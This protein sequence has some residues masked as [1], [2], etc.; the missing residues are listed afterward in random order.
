MYK[1]RPVLLTDL[2]EAV[3]C[4]LQSAAKRKR[5]WWCDTIDK[6]GNTRLNSC[7]LN[8]LKRGARVQGQSL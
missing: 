7:G 3:D 2:M 8:Y 6:E 1:T 4:D 5:S